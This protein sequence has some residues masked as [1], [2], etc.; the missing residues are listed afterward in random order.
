MSPTI[1]DAG[2]SASASANT[3][4]TA[5]R[6]SVRESED[7][8]VEVFLRSLGAPVGCQDQQS[9]VIRTLDR[10]EEAG[11]VSASTVSVWGDRIYLSDRCSRTPVGEFVLGKIDEFTGW[12]RERDG[13]ELEFERREVDSSITGETYEM[14]RPPSVCLAVY[15]A[16]ELTGV[17][18]CSMGDRELCVQSYLSE[19]AEL[20]GDAHKLGSTW[21]DTVTV[22]GE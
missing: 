6:R 18:P 17:F 12:A 10:L 7:V 21:D 3:D 5:H 14:I 4:W 15:A 9:T 13:V 22:T 19:L 16:D 8:R 2:A 20:S 1:D 11:V